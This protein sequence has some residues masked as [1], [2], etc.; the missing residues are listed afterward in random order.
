MNNYTIPGPGD[1]CAGCNR[2]L[3][4]CGPEPDEESD[5]IVSRDYADDGSDPWPDDG[6]WLD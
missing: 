2:L 3:C 4:C 1:F 5:R 6:D